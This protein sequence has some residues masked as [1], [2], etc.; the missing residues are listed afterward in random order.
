VAFLRFLALRLARH[1]GRGP[2][3]N[4]AAGRRD[5]LAGLLVDP[6]VEVA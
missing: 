5:A 1:V 2:G 3:A 4:A 6:A